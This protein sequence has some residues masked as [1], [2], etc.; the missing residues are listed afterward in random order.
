[1]GLAKIY[2]GGGCFGLID[3]SPLY[4]GEAHLEVL[5]CSSWQAT[6]KDIFNHFIAVPGS[7]NPVITVRM[8]NF[9]I[10]AIFGPWIF[11]RI[12]QEDRHMTS[13]L[14]MHSQRRLHPGGSA[15]FDAGYFSNERS[16]AG[17]QPA[18]SP[19]NLREPE[20]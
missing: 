8:A 20:E 9:T 15:R 18:G 1:M 7:P 19:K 17:K 12:W 2:S 14:N 11:I 4:D 16:A 5:S 6:W 10:A 3:A 13:P